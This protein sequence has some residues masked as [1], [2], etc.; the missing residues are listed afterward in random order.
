MNI[1]KFLMIA[2]TW[3]VVLTLFLIVRPSLF[4][5]YF[6]PVIYLAIPWVIILLL[7]ID[8][9]RISIKEVIDTNNHGGVRNIIVSSIYLIYIFFAVITL[10]NP[11][12][13]SFFDVIITGFARGY[14]HILTILAQWTVSVSN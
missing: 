11:G 12:S 13:K 7:I 9:Y 10:L 14:I 6:F 4:I 1:K 3:V 2:N 5:F 8:S